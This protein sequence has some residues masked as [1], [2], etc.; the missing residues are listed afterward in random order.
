MS[1]S[2]LRLCVY[3]WLSYYVRWRWD[4]FQHLSICCQVRVSSRDHVLSCQALSAAASRSPDAGNAYSLP[5]APGRVHQT[6]GP[7]PGSRREAGR[8]GRW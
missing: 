1:E 8:E 4:E 5:K 3:T 7:C 6:L 2:S